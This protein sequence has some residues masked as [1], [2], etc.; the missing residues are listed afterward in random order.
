M[1]LDVDPRK[2]YARSPLRSTSVHGVLFPLTETYHVILEMGQEGPYTRDHLALGKVRSAN[3]VVGDE[4]KA[5]MSLLEIITDAGDISKVRVATTE[6]VRRTSSDRHKSIWVPVG[7]RHANA[8]DLGIRSHREPWER[9][10][11]ARALRIS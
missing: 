6:R 7:D 2:T 11:P 5:V 9:R 4:T 1:A 10:A 8:N 3:W